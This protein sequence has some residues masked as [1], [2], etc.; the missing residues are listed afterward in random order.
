MPI[1]QCNPSRKVLQIEPKGQLREA[2]N[3][4]ALLSLHVTQ[5]IVKIR[6]KYQ[7]I[8]PILVHVIH[9]SFQL[10]N[11]I[12]NILSWNLYKYYMT[13]N[14]I[15]PNIIWKTL[16]HETIETGQTDY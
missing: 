5:L 3:Q 16:A 11:K 13:D 6:V 15:S 8:P 1:A 9:S 10:V 14:H 7:Q 12:K 4:V 2:K